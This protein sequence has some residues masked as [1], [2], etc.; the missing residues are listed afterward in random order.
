MANVKFSHPLIDKTEGSLRITTGANQITWGYGLNTAVYPTYGGEVVQV[1]SAYT[2]D[3]TIGGDVK[4]Y[5]QMEHI[6]HWFLKYMQIA[7]QG[8]VG[9][10]HF[11]EAPVTMYYPL[12]GWK[13]K[14]R[15]T[16]LP[17]FRYGREVVAPTW[18]LQASVAEEDPAMTAMTLDEASKRGFD[19]TRLHAGIGY[20]N[21]NPFTDPAARHDKYNPRQATKDIS[22][23][24]TKLIPAYL[25]HDFDSLT[26]Q[27]YGSGPVQNTKSDQ[28]SG[29]QDSSGGSAP[30]NGAGNIVGAEGNV[31]NG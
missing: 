4:T 30:F 26:T 21:E 2:D 31:G 5:A 7:T 9:G 14:I 1:L 15:P 18:Q 22:D 12:R 16:S 19:F 24:Y 29:Q 17:G 23:F 6:Y 28:A 27:A 20:D 11:N 13:L 3:L 10:V 8:E 25:A